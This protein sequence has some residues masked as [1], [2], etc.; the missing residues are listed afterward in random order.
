MPKYEVAPNVGL[1][2]EDFGDGKAI[3]FTSAGIQT[4]KMWEHQAAALSS[5]YRT[6]TYDWRGPGRSDRP[7]CSYGVD[8]A[9][10]DLCALVETLSIAPAMLVGHGSGCHVTLLATHR[11]P[12]RVE[13]MV[14]VSGAPWYTGDRGDEGGVSDEFTTWWEE[15]TANQGT[16]IAQA[17]AD[18]CERFLFYKDPGPAVEHSVLEQALDW[19]LFVFKSYT[20]SMMT[21]DHREILPKV[22]CPTLIFQ[23]L[24]DKKQRYGG[25]RYLAEHIPSA[26]L[27]TFKES[28][29]MPQVEEMALFNQILD[30]FLSDAKP[31]S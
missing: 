24:H 19:P 6:I 13:R 8:Q 9:V 1:Y 20:G 15:Q 2:C 11:R 17:Y 10:D 22:N 18:L 3:I 30:E 23:G 31:N 7:R 12:E 21:L 26:R 5:K 25:G 14:L 28:A 29:H 27:I 4:R 16:H